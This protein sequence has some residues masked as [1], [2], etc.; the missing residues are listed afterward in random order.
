MRTSR[1]SL[2]AAAR[3]RSARI[4]STWP[5][6]SRSSHRRWQK[7]SNSSGSSQAVRR[8]F[9][10]ERP[11]VRAFRETTSLPAGER[12]PRALR[13]LRRLARIC[14]R[15]AMSFGSCIQVEGSS[16]CHFVRLLR[17]IKKECPSTLYGG[18][19]RNGSVLRAPK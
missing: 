2:Q 15:V 14:L 1:R 5:T 18:G 17:E 7:R 11:W 10:A 8:C 4:I 3:I 19:D 13:A 6:G 16:C 12:G 9:L